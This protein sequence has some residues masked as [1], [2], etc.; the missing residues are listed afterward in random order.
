MGVWDKIKN[1]IG[2][3]TDDDYYDDEYYDDENEDY[4]EDEPPRKISSFTRKSSSKV[5]P[6][7]PVNLSRVRIIK[8]ENID[9]ATK[10][11]DEVKGGRLVIFD[12]TNTDTEEAR[13]IVDFVAGA[14]YGVNGSCRRVGGGV[15]VAAPSNMD[16]TGDNI[17]EQ[18]R[19]RFDWNM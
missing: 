15:F 8:P 3:D 12:V 10:V 14:V 9:A 19:N 11:A 4:D 18:A 16:I 7:T 2:M 13:R 6:I 1:F 5:I 17:K